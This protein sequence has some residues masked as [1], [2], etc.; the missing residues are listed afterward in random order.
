MHQSHFC[1]LALVGLGAPV[2]ADASPTAPVTLYA[3]VRYGDGFRA[4]AYESLS[5]RNPRASGSGLYGIR[6]SGGSGWAWRSDAEGADLPKPDNFRYRLVIFT[7]Q[8]GAIVM[9]AVALPT[10][11]TRFLAFRRVVT[12]AIGLVNP[13]RV[14]ALSPG[15]SSLPW[16][17]H[18]ADTSGQSSR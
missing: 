12:A 8:S 18:E 4:L 3:D 11:R 9:L 7:A 1:V 13:C 2:W 14:M 6:I 17:A 10:P 5:C 16:A 15:W